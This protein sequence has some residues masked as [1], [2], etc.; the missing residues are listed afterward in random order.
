MKRL[1]DYN[2]GE[3]DLFSQE[4][5]VIRLALDYDISDLELFQ[6]LLLVLVQRFRFVCFF[7]LDLYS[8][9]ADFLLKSGDLFG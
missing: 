8:K 4:L 1:F 6:I 9:V 3:A 5:R 7:L 2:L